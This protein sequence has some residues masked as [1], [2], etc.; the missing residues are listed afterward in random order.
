MTSNNLDNIY[1]LAFHKNIDSYPR[2]KPTNGSGDALF[3]GG[4]MSGPPLY[5]CNSYK[6][7]GLKS[8]IVEN[9]G[10]ILFNGPHMV[11]SDQVKTYLDSFETRFL[12]IYP[13]VYIDNQDN[14]H[15]GYWYL[16]FIDQIDCWD[17]ERSVFDPP[18]DPADPFDY[19]E[20]KKYSLDVDVLDR[21]P[22]DERLLFKMGGA[23]D[24]R[25]TTQLL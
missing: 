13:A 11:V 2:V 9:I 14:W 17:R 22:E 4:V 16:N 6:D 15:E 5:F 1:Y 12:Q 25:A 23:L 21:I 24:R 19:A 3:D 10:D 18:D 7:E 8:G 20:V